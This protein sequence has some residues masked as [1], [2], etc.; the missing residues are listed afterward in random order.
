M[1][2]SLTREQEMLRDMTR[3]FAASELAPR[4]LELEEEG[5]FPFDVA[6]RMAELGL[7]GLSSPKEY[8]GSDIAFP[9]LII[10]VEELAR[11][12]PAM[13]LLC[14]MQNEFSLF[15]HMHGTQ[16]IKRRLIPQLVKGEKFINFALTE[17]SGGS[18]PSAMQA[19]AEL[20]GDEYVL[21]G[22]KVWIV[23]A[24]LAECTCVAAKTEEGISVFLVE[25]G[26]PGYEI[27][28]RQ[29]ML[30][31]RLMP[32]GELALVNC[33]IPKENLLGEKGQGLRKTMEILNTFGRLGT[34]AC[35]LGI[36]EGAYEVALKYAKERNLYGAPIARLQAIQFRLVD[37]E[38]AIEEA[39]WLLYHSAWVA[40]Q[41]A[42]AGEVAKATAMAKLR[43]T[44][45]ARQAVID[46]MQI[47]GA[48]G[49][50]PEY[51]LVRRMHDALAFVAA[52]GSLEIMRVTI[53][54]ESTK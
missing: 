20:V 40:H 24:P 8:G 48:Y 43:T 41:G 21:N 10:A 35:C 33:K 3:Q 49:L 44:E 11:V 39:R 38:V 46:S 22:R 29:E 37:L 12:S 16:E 5:D 34:S 1:D 53:G 7:L 36:A 23:L 27:G 19:T 2:F 9:S 14:E 54:R 13:G 18:N 32:I 31:L 47:L 30:G 26:T 52:P 17:A 45:L 15:L 4:I 42:S 51:H 28:R 25:K 50:A 6:K